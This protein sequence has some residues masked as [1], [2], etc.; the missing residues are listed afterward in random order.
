MLRRQR[1]DSE[2]VQPRAGDA[3]GA[4]RLDQRLLLHDRAARGVDQDRAG[5]H[6]RELRRRDEALRLRGEPQVHA[7]HVARAIELV[8]L[9]ELHARIERRVHRPHDHTHPKRRRQARELP[10]DGAVADHA[11]RLAV[12]FHPPSAGPRAEARRGVHLRNAAR[13]RE[14][15]G[16][17]VLGDGARA[18]SGRVGDR[19]AVLC[20][21]GQIDVV[22]AGAPYREQSQPG[23]GGEDARRESRG[24]ADIQHRLGRADALDQHVFG[25]GQCIVIVEFGARLKGEE[26]SA[27]GEDHR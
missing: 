9:D 20:C 1:L 11:A 14:Q 15:Q 7:H 22:G 13:H 5:L 6:Q 26:D 17:R 24:G 12:Q 25:P 27:G 23:A 21:A 2:N 16:E 8:E 4:E 10:P 18:H 3:A 19:D